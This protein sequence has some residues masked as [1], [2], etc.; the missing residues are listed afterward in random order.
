METPLRDQI[1]QSAPFGSLEQEAFLN[2]LR[3]AAALE[4][5]MT[6]RLKPYGLTLTQYNVLRILRGAGPEG[7]CRNE[8]GARMLTPV[9]DA[10]RLLDRMVDAGLVVKQREGVDRRYVSTR[11]TERGLELL[12]ALDGPVA[13]MHRAQLGH[14]SQEELRTLAHLLEAA[15]VCP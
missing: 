12:S 2:V 15:R 1:K 5:A 6:A 3:T 8:V 11:I 10:T 7:L 4:H 14:L 13:E 9:P